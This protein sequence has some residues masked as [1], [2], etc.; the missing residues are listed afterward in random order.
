MSAQHGND[1]S[2]CEVSLLL[3]AILGPPPPLPKGGFRDLGD[4]RG[5]LHMSSASHTP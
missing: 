3:V 2:T 1:S 4:P 5:W